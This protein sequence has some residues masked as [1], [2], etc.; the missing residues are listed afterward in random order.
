MWRSF[1]TE[2]QKIVLYN[3]KSPNFDFVPS[4]LST[5]KTIFNAAYDIIKG[6]EIQLKWR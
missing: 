4:L 1:L 2:L 5:I 6:F 3:I